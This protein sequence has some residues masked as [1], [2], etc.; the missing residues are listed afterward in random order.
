MNI[1]VINIVILF[2]LLSLLSFSQ[3][4]TNIHFEQEGKQIHIYY[5]LEGEGFFNVKV[6][7][8]ED[9]GNTWGKQLEKVKGAVG[10]NQIPDKNKMII[11]DVL[12]EREELRGNLR[13]KVDVHTENRVLVDE[14]INKGSEYSPLMYSADGLYTGVGFDVYPDGQLKEE[15]AFKDGSKDGLWKVW[16][17]NGQLK[18]E[19]AWKDGRHYGLFRNWYENGQLKWEDNYKD[20]NFDGLSKVWYENGQLKYELNYKDDE[21]DGLWKSWY[22]N[23][24]LKYINNYENG[25]KD[26]V[27]KEWYENGQLGFEINY[28]DGKKDGLER[29]WYENGKLRDYNVYKDGRLLDK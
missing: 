23:G 18:E 2:L 6:Y 15:G 11:W 14:L 9:N 16:Y 24:K 7:C 17:E 20:G 3:Q 4:I 1:K 10:E 8:S 19:G 27:Q 29:S 5:D 25:N 22:E 13:F 28:K 26:G 12:Q 21:L